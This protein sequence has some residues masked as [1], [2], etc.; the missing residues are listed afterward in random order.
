MPEHAPVL[1]QAEKANAEEHLGLS[2]REKEV[3]ALMLKNMPLKAIAS[4]LG[5]AFNTVNFHYRS[6]YRKLGINS[7]GELF[8]KYIGKA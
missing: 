4:E 6:I 1:A 2:P 3:F 5:I 8:M 7:K